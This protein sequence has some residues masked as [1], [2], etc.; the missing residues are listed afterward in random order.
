MQSVVRQLF[1]F[2]TSFVVVALGQGLAPLVQ[3]AEVAKPLEP[4]S[5]GSLLD[6]SSGVDLWWL[7]GAAP[8]DR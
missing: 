2:L 4:N 1:I 7:P 5:S 8:G 6:A 3:H